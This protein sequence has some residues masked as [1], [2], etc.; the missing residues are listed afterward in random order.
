MV[1]DGMSLVPSC[2]YVFEYR[3]FNFKVKIYPTG[4][5]ESKKACVVRATEIFV[6]A[7]HTLRQMDEKL[8]ADD[9]TV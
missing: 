9:N 4:G 7:S 1:A 6:S 2:F 8:K 3:E 5:S